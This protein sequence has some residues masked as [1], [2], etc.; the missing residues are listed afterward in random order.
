MEQDKI[1]ALWHLYISNLYDV[2]REGI[3]QI[4]TDT[5]LVPITQM[6]IEIAVKGIPIMKAPRPDDIST[7]MLLATGEC[8][9]TEFKNSK[10]D[11]QRGLFSSAAEQ[12]KQLA[13]CEKHCKISLMSHTTKLVPSVIV[14]R[15]RVRTLGEISNVHYLLLVT[16][17]CSVA[18]TWPPGHHAV[19]TIVKQSP[20]SS[21]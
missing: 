10:Y 15:L 3:P 12:I 1:V 5:E 20:P 11:A 13:K 14:W 8:E 4:N 9:V 21:Y 19:T 6:V 2:I 18:S 17:G 7:K 16:S